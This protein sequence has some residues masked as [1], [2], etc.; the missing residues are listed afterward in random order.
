M[1]D[2]FGI[3]ILHRL[4]DS[5]IGNGPVLDEFAILIS[6]VID[7]IKIPGIF[8]E[9]IKAQLEIHVLQDQQ[10]GSHADREPDHIDERENLILP[11]I[12]PRG[13]KIALKHTLGITPQRRHLK[14]NVAPA[15]LA[16]AERAFHQ[17]SEVQK[18]HKH[19]IIKYLWVKWI[20][21]GSNQRPADYESAALTN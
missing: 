16:A 4:S 21:L 18:T 14:P 9:L 17:A 3:I 6:V 20:L 1:R 15:D 2:H 19:L 10:T 8:I 13:S 7:A 12:T 11:D 5:G